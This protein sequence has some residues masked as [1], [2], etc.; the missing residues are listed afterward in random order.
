MSYSTIIGLFHVAAYIRLSREDGD[1]E[2]S[3]S[4]GNQRK[5]L[6]EY[7]RQKEDLKLYDIYI[8]DG[9][10]GLNF[11]RPSFQRMLT[12]IDA[13]KINC[14]IV[15]DLSRIGR[16]H[17][18]T[19]RFL[20]R[21]FPEM[22][23][24]FISVTDNIDSYQQAYDL[25][26]PIKNL[27]NEQY[28]RDISKKVYTAMKTKQQAGEFIG[29][30]AS[31][32]Y[33]KSP[34]N[35]NKLVID[36]PAAEVVRRIFSMYLEGYGKRTIAS[37]LN[38]ENIPCPSE[39]KRLNGENYSNCHRLDSTTY[40]TYSTIHTILQREMYTGCMVQGK[41]HQQMKGKARPVA[42]KDWIIVPDTHDAII[43]KDTWNKVQH[44]LQRQHR[45]LGLT[46]NN[47]I[48]AG[49]LKCGDCGRAMAKKS[50]R[51]KSGVEYYFYCGTY[52]RHG[53]KYCTPHT[54]PSRVL[55]QIVLQDLKV[56]VRNIDNLQK[57]V[58]DQ[59]KQFAVKKNS[60]EKQLAQLERELQRLKVQKKSVYRDYKEDLISREEFVEYHADY[61]EKEDHLQK[62]IELLEH[63]QDKEPKHVFSENPWIRR[64]LELR[65]IEALDRDIVL[66]MIDSIIVY[67]NHRI[68]IR[69]HFSDDLESLLPQYY[70]EEQKDSISS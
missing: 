69:Y 55:E 68:V 35:K 46:K 14:V 21:V 39:Y 24:R 48:F 53:K 16:D 13:K 57:I 19:S 10:T 70:A 31:Y 63:V 8:D 25:I 66:E 59:T 36:E 30:F 51:R 61:Q 37:C 22:G 26:L 67:E 41:I 4:V 9:Y 50:F 15:K 44:L 60:Y 20:E 34:T 3:D 2:E 18:E 47:S 49:F 7:I 23:V 1:K 6:L 32:G 12:D 33:K 17:I 28:A 42:Q 45:D 58:E 56:I 54:I 29:A 5:L 40:W 65:D 64:L 38:A 27:F 62:K 11:N 52:Q 43:D